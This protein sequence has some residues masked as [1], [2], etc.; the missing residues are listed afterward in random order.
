MGADS[1]PSPELFFDT[2]TAYQKT[3]ALK[4]AVDLNLFTAIGR[5]SGKLV[6]SLAVH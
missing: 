4:A 3:A 2:I 5:G 6:L 1:Q